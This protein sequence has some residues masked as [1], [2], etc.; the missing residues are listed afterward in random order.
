VV[1]NPNPGAEGRRVMDDLAKRLEDA[2]RTGHRWSHDLRYVPAPDA[3]ACESCRRGD[4]LM[5]ELLAPA[6]RAD[7]ERLIEKARA[8]REHLIVWCDAACR[9]R[10]AEDG[11]H[12]QAVCFRL[13]DELGVTLVGFIHRLMVIAY[14]HSHGRCHWCSQGDGWMDQ[15]FRGRERPTKRNPKT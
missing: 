1:H 12:A 14:T 2:M 15:I 10:S 6:T 3:N 13:T 8:Y 7:T 11:E 9:R 5:A 4:A